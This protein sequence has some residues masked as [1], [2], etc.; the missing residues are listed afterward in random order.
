MK[1]YVCQIC[2]RDWYSAADREICSE[3]RGELKEVNIN[4]KETVKA[5][6]EAATSLGAKQNI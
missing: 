2:G 3:C 6:S 4:M 5:P 1:K